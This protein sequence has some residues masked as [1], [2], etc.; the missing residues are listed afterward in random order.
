MQA[1]DH[2]CYE[3][4]G[5]SPPHSLCPTIAVSL[6]LLKHPRHS[7]SE[8]LS[9]LV[10]LPGTDTRMLGHSPTSFGSLSRCLPLKEAI[11][12]SVISNGPLNLC[13]LTHSIFLNSIM[14][15]SNDRMYL[16]FVCFSHE[17]GLEVCDSL[18]YPPAPR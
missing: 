5:H 7:C 14:T 10:P 4:P 3:I 16:C 1:H 9:L 15:I 8:P 2:C 6:L 13:L 17:H 12:D 18:L 11:P